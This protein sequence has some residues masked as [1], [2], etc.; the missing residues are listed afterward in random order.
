VHLLQD[1]P[2]LVETTLAYLSRSE[3]S[4]GFKGDLNAPR[5]KQDKP[6]YDKDNL[7]RK[8][9]K[10]TIDDYEHLSQSQDHLCAICRRPETKPSKHGT[11]QSL[12]LDRNIQS[13]VIRGLLCASCKLMLFGINEELELLRRIIAYLTRFR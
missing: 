1:S 6:R 10:I 4:A 3:V 7:L 8:R 11:I 12:S 5:P 2:S 9:Y 13:N